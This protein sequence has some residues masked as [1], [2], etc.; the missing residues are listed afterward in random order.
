[1]TSSRALLSALHAAAVQGAAPFLRTRQTVDQWLDAHTVSPDS[2]SAPIHLFALGKAA[3]AMAEGACAALEARGL[4]VAGGI[5]VSNHLPDAAH[6]GDFAALPEVLRRCLGDHPVPG[7]A[8]LEAADAI[9]DAIGDVVPGA[10]ALVLLSGGTTAL[11][12]AP[13]PALSQAV[14]DTDRAQ[15]HVANLAQTLLESGLAIHEMNAIRRRVLRFGAGRLASALARRGVRRIGTFAISDVIGDHP[16]VIGSGP[17]SADILTDEE[18]LALLDAHDLRGRLER[19]MS[20]VL[21]LEG[22]GLPPAVPVVD[23][24]AFGLV[25]YTL[26][27]TNRDA[28]GG[29]AEAAR[30]Q[31]IANVLVEAEPLAGD[32]D[33]VGRALVVRAL[34]MAAAFPRGTPLEGSTVLLSG[35]EPVVNLRDTIERA[36]RHGDEDDARRAEAEADTETRQPAPAA[37][38]EPMR[39]GR[40][41]VVGLAAALALEEAAMR[42]NPHAWQIAVLAAGTDGR[43]G[44]TDAAGAIVDAAVPA[45]ARRAGRTPEGDLETGRSWFSLHAADALLRTGPTGTNVMDVVAV[46]IRP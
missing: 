16:A 34:R 4:S 13:I 28:V 8:S 42:G 37:A 10:L 5:V 12:A 27:A 45:L 26:V 22:R 36:V 44:P 2:A 43:D 31:G 14:G 38:D 19:A 40:M 29:M 20:T 11:C 39:G 41:Q 33:A 35:G 1:M 18:F 32:A 21:G 6:P 15:A 9:D 30:A 3:W 24:P 46:L 23:D 7:P 17:C 25:D